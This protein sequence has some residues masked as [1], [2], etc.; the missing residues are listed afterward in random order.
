MNEERPGP[1]DA[2]DGPESRRIHVLGVA[3]AMAG[4]GALLYF[5]ALVPT[6]FAAPFEIPIWVIALAFAATEVFNIHLHVRANAHTVSMSEIPLIL[7][8]VFAGP[9]ALIAGRLVGAGVAR[10]VRRKQPPYRLAFNLALFFLETVVALTAYGF[11]LDGRS[12]VSMAGLGAGMVALTISMVVSAGFVTLAVWLDQPGRALGAVARSMGSGMVISFLSAVVGI[13]SLVVAWRDPLALVAVAVVAGGMYG[14]LRVYGSLS[15]RFEDLESVYAFTSSI[16]AAVDTDELIEA[17]LNQ[18]VDLFDAE[19][20]EVVM[21]R[22]VGSTAVT[23]TAD[24]SLLRRP[25]PPGVVEAITAHVDGTAVFRL[26][27]LD[28]AIVAHYSSKGITDAMAALLA[29]GG[30]TATMIVVGRGRKGGGFTS[31][32]MRLFDSLARQARL[33]FERGRLVDRLRREAGQKEHQALHDALTN[34]P[35][36]LHFS[37]VV[38]DALRKAQERG[39]R[40]AVLLVD[41]DRFKEVN[42]TLGHQRGDVLLQEMAL[43]LSDV[44]GGDEHIARL[45]GDEFGIML[46][47]ISG[48]SEAV[49]WARKIG[50]ALHR[51][52][53]NEGLAIQV[54]GSIGIAMA[55][56]HG[57]DG[58]TLLRRADVAMYEAK[59][60]GSSFEVYDPHQDQYSTRRLAMAAELRDALD[61]GSIAINYQPQARLSDGTPVGI[62]ALARWLHPRHGAVPPDEF[63][64]LAERTGLIRPLTE[65]VL[66]TAFRD[67]MRLRGDGHKISVSVN[68]A[69]ASLTDDEFPD[70]VA[71]LI[72]ENDVDPQAVT[73]E[74][75]ETTMMTDSARARLVL[76]AL[77]EL[78]VKLAIDD[79][80]TG[81]SSLAY[82]SSLPVDEVKI[83]RSFVMDMAVDQRLAKIVTSTTSLVHS[84][85]LVVV[86]EG[87]ENH[88]T[89]DLLKAAGCDVAQGYYLGRPMPFTD[90]SAWLA[91]GAAP[92]G[93]GGPRVAFGGMT[94]ESA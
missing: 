35:N 12:P 41:L 59:S 62:E 1:L 19:F 49:D 57:T 85:G 83:D 42:D 29:G 39:G 13:V 45:G 16:D 72:G 55:P 37:I 34:L 43:R 64:E 63:I 6:P 31:D 24:G 91:S 5:F 14:A 36:R 84:L 78:G 87:V 56:D 4:A 94:A 58:T 48:I 32:Q 27:E 33:S 60:V 92:M 75:T 81:Y 93:D 8:V 73:L 77:D 46:R 38:E 51:P 47:D 53:L 86:A 2:P 65:H 70:L 74:V 88:G 61:Q 25:A 54:S 15:Q 9:V 79:F 40:L 22:G 7:G 66:R 90:L 89:W 44:L 68:I 23:R 52:F 20:A 76:N 69:A 11:V 26:Y 3:V 10:A 80:G 28:S 30:G 50:Q 17:T 82:L 18:T 71:R 67:V 21:A